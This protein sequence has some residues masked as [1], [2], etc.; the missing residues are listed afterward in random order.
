MAT[1]SRGGF[2]SFGVAAS[3]STETDSPRRGPDGD[4]I[5][6]DSK[7]FAKGLLRK[8]DSALVFVHLLS[9][10][11]AARIRGIACSIVAS[12]AGNSFSVTGPEIGRE[13]LRAGATVILNE[14]TYL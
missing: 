3:L 8:P 5:T 14:R 7:R 11:L 9:E 2:Q 10:P 1:C 12:G 6:Q 4:C 13:S